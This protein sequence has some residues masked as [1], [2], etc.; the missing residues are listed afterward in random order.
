MRRL[1]VVAL[2]VAVLLV[3]GLLCATSAPAKPRCI[4]HGPGGTCLVWVTDPGHP[5]GGRGNDGG[6]G[7]LVCVDDWTHKVVDC[8]DPVFGWWVPSVHGWCKLAEPQPPKSDVSWEGHT[9]GAIYECVFNIHCTC[10]GGGWVWLPTPPGPPIDPAQLARQ[11][12]KT[13]NIPVPVTGRYPNGRLADGRPYTVVK[14]YTWYW[15][16]PASFRTLTARAS[17]GP[18]WAEVTV[19]PTA[20]TFTPG[21]GSSAV[22]CAGPGSAWS[23]AYGP[24]APSPT[25]CDYRYPHSSLHYRHGEV[26]A[27]YGITWRVTWTSSTGAGGTM[28]GMTTIATATFAVAELQ[29]IVVR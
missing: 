22:S 11:A 8:R 16:S 5:G 21:D 20:L 7:S 17:L 10:T 4:Q 23:A 1:S 18:V 24:W 3:T 26:T 15:T 9:D 13:M 25:G 29:S 28:P 6:G 14:A 27:T 12:L 19:T 2:G